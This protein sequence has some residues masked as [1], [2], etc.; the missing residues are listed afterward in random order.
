MFAGARESG[1]SRR[2]NQRSG[3]RSRSADLIASL[4]Y[5]ADRQPRRSCHLRYPP[6]PIASASAPAHRRRPRSFM[7]NGADTLT[8]A[9]ST[10]CGFSL[11][12]SPFQSDARRPL[13]PGASR[14]R[15]RRTGRRPAGV[16]LFSFISINWR[17]RPLR[18]SETVIN[19]I[20][21]TTN[22][23]GLVVRARLDRR[24]YPIGKKVSAKEL[25]EFNIERADFHG[26]WDYVIR[27]RPKH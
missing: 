18:S 9:T 16:S 21:N 13:R 4:A 8:S 10:R 27:P 20:S 22:R 15:G 17:G 26:D 23:G 12:P 14:C 11:S 19:L 3:P 24:A 2:Q 1:R 7:V 25:R 5:R 6:R